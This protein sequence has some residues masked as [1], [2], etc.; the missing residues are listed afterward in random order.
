MNH[1]THGYKH[2]VGLSESNN[3]FL[4][5]IY[6]LLM[7]HARIGFAPTWLSSL[8]SFCL[9]WQFLNIVKPC[10][11]YPF[12]D[13]MTSKFSLGHQVAD[14]CVVLR[15]PLRV[16]TLLSWDE[17]SPSSDG[18]VSDTCFGCDLGWVSEFAETSV[19]VSPPYQMAGDGLRGAFP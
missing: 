3:L 8:F 9:N 14:I 13:I 10:R 12:H 1:I 7:W 4:G 15:G 6:L 19:I 5:L 2:G 18:K 11:C 16:R 17:D